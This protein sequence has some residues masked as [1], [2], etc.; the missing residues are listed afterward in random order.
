M[1]R[2]HRLGQ[3]RP[4]RV[5]RFAS[6]GTIEERILQ[7]QVI[8]CSTG[9]NVQVDMFEQ[10]KKTALAATTLASS[11]SKTPQEAFEPDDDQDQVPRHLFKSTAGSTRQTVRETAAVSRTNDL[12]ALF[13]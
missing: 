11:T 3:T 6:R 5:V 2:V 1:D 13:R 9:K 4:V 7:L 8:V 12:A 10:E